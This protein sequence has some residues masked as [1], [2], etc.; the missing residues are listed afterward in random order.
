MAKDNI[1][2]CAIH[3]TFEGEQCWRLIDAFEQGECY[4][5]VLN[6]WGKPG[7]ETESPG[8]QV[9]IKKPNF[10]L[11]SDP[12]TPYELR[13]LHSVNFDEMVFTDVTLDAE[14]VW[15]SGHNLFYPRPDDEHD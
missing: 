14:K 12:N 15:R 3:C 7:E 4:V 9:G 13:C 11:I 2:R 1:L 10:E 6:W 8:K 5:L